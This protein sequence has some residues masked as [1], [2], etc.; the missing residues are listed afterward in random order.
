VRE[1]AGGHD[2]LGLQPLHEPR[3]TLLDLA[4]LLC[5]RVEVGYMEEPGVHD[6]T[7]L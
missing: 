1:I 6:R 3:Q 2:Q 4:L 7:R 5:T